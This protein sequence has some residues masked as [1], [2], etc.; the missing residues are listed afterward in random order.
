MMGRLLAGV[1]KELLLL[2]RDRSGLA[3][4]FIMPAILVVVISLI[5]ENV[6]RTTGQARSRVL[7]VDGDGGAVGEILAREMS[8]SAMLDLTR[9]RA[10]EPEV[11]ARAIASARRGESQVVVIL[12][13][14][15]SAAL[16]D[17]A[18]RAARSFFSPTATDTAIRTPLPDIEVHFDPLVYGAL[19]AAIVNML[20]RLTLG[21]ESRLRFETLAES[22]P[23]QIEAMMQARGC[24]APL[25]SIPPAPAAPPHP[26]TAGLLQVV[27]RQ[28]GPGGSL[29]SAAQQN[30][31]AWTLFGMFFIVVPMA[32]GLVRERQEMI[33]A[34]LMTL[35]V[36]PL[37]LLAGRVLTYLAVCLA[38]AL[39]IAA[40]G[41]FL[42]PLL[43]ASQLELGN[44][45]PAALL[46]MALSS[47]LAAA[48]YGILVGSLARSYEQASI[49][50]A[51]SVV[52][53][54]AIG[55][56]MVPVFA[57]PPTM[58]RLSALS[59]L[60][61]G[62]EGFLD[63]L[64]RGGQIAA[65]G[66]EALRLLGFGLFCLIGAAAVIGRRGPGAA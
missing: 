7:M 13:A 35:P 32:G 37:L 58:Q 9:Q 11:T 48:G 2:R 33:L 57:M 64:V 60:N 54:A 3:L 17:E 46:L 50:G 23:A 47:A 8:A 6:L 56:V 21:V 19:R 51:I 16:R 45:P 18:Q 52:V 49:F 5:Q 25:L 24:A 41:R 63:L 53:A 26:V 22:A 27:E 62:L 38:Q 44:A 55:G 39:L 14:G 30:V 40:I 20:G 1:A 29:P 28:F 59:P 34:R 15:L 66:P 4:L 65:V 10:M 31:P 43:G 12:P 36:S 61:W 42:L